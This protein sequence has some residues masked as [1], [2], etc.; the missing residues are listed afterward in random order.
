MVLDGLT[1][2]PAPAPAPTGDLEPVGLITLP[3]T[4]YHTREQERYQAK[5]RYYR[6]HASKAS[7]DNSKQ[8]VCMRF[9]SHNAVRR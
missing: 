9:V 7:R 8:A 1:L 3:S 2:S 4:S 6:V 5:V